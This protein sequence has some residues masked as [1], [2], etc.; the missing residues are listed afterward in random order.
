MMSLDN[1][2]SKTSTF[3]LDGITSFISALCLVSKNELDNFFNPRNY[4]LHKLVEVADFNI[5]RIQIEWSKIWKLISDHLVFVATN[6]N[7][8]NIC[9]DAIDSLRQT[10]TKLLQKRDNTSRIVYI[11]DYK[12]FIYRK[13]PLK[14]ACPIIGDPV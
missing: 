7:H 12:I 9:I 6:F 10:V 4:S 11:K 14:R 13:F 2:F 5:F 3:N 8:D 1:I